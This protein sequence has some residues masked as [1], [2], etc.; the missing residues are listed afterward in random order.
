M[1]RREGGRTGRGEDAKVEE[2]GAGTWVGG[3]VGCELGGKGAAKW[4]SWVDGELQ[5][6]WNLSQLGWQMWLLVG[7]A[8]LVIGTQVGVER[9][10][11]KQGTRGWRGWWKVSLRQ[12]W[13]LGW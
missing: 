5:N 12:D 1:S 3:K 11:G 10:G 8:G 6:G 4:R 7:K 2:K 13:E 9:R